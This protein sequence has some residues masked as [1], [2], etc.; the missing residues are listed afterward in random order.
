M[1]DKLS[2]F[3]NDD[4]APAALRTYLHEGRFSGSWFERLGGRGDAG[5]TANTFTAADLVAV[6][7]LSVQVPG[8]AA[9]ELLDRRANEFNAAL[10]R[11]PIDV[12]LHE[13]TDELLDDVYATQ[14]LV[15]TLD[16]IGHVTRSKLLAR[17]R[18]HLIPI[19]DQHVLTAL[20]G[21]DH[22]DF[23]QP[24]RD[25]LT[26]DPELVDR[27]DELR[28]VAG[29]PDLALIRIIDIVVWMI[30]HGA[31]SIGIDLDGA[32]AATSR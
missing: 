32:T 22:G 15:D 6:T 7:T 20:T 10:A 4:R 1:R 23:T 12:A 26:G 24:L 16:G 2:N 18:P 17:K 31:P 29:R 21:T 3:L 11:L 28:R 25:T 14:R 30:T 8:W 9:V 5:E 27:L 19:R 13:A